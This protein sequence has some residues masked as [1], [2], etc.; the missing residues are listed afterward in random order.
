MGEIRPLR[1]RPLR[2]CPIRVT[3]EYA[4]I[5]DFLADIA[6]HDA[7]GAVFIP[8]TFPLEE[9]SRFRLRLSVPGRARPI[10]VEAEVT[11]RVS[12]QDPS[13][14]V[15]G[16]GVRYGPMSVEDARFVAGLVGAG[17]REAA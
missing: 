17:A 4:C 16:M 13:G 12:R 1:Q 7:V 14:M 9:G 6:A 3:V 8:S 2:R 5:D 11:W 10:Q 15:A